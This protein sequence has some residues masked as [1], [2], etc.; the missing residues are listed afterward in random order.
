[1]KR[2]KKL[3]K[4]IVLCGKDKNKIGE[5][6]DLSWKHNR[7]KVKDVNVVTCHVKARKQGEASR[8]KKQEAFIHVS[9]VMPIDPLTGKP[10]RH[11]KNKNKNS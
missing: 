4:V 1:M 7:V 2:L 3:D 8:I 5:I 6:I 10:M 9:N 11:N